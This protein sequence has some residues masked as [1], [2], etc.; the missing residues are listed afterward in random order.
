M[1]PRHSRTTCA[2]LGEAHRQGPVG[3]VDFGVDV[4]AGLGARDAVRPD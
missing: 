3:G 2:D 1:T 4:D